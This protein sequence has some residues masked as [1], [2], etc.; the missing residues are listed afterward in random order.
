MKTKL[1]TVRYISYAGDL[2]S[3]IVEADVNSISNYQWTRK[4]DCDHLKY[5]GEI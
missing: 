4:K 1:W 3:A 5:K 2:V